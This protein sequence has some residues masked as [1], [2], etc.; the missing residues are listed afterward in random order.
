MPREALRA[1]LGLPGDAFEDLVGS[2]DGVV[3]DGTVVRSAEHRVRLQPEQEA[4]A[5]ALVRRLH[6]AGF[7]P[8]PTKD[9]AVDPDLLRVLEQRGDIVRIGDFHL[10]AE[11]AAQAR[12][13]VRGRIAEQ[14]PM[15]VAQIRDLLGTSRRYAVP[16]CGWLDA[17]GATRRR[18][19]ERV[20]GPRD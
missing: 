6:D 10:S 17:T 7:S 3:G 12:T 13:L 8:P 4:A 15:T 14:G 18:G 2:V 11:R 20:L 5:R 16:L 9:L 1:R 19:D